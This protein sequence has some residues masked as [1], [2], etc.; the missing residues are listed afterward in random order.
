MTSE[1]KKILG[2]VVLDPDAWMQNAINVFGEEK[3]EEAL[4]AKVA[5]YQDQYDAAIAAGTY[6]TKA[7]EKT[8]YEASPEYL[9][10]KADMAAQVVAN[11]K[12]MQAIIDNLPSWSVVGGKF[13]SMLADAKAATNLAQAKAVLV[14]LITFLKKSHR[15]LYWEVKNTEE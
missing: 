3:A 4:I 6:K 8:E 11:Q 13:D 10:Q 7:Q 15:V 12:K 1:Q 9:A 2:M 14:E 5:K